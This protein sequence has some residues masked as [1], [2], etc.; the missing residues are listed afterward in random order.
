MQKIGSIVWY[1]NGEPTAVESAFRSA[2][3]REA[4]EGAGVHVGW[5]MRNGT[6][7]RYGTKYELFSGVEVYDKAA[8]LFAIRWS[9]KRA[10]HRMGV[11]LQFAMAEPDIDNMFAKLSAAESRCSELAT[12]VSNLKSVVRQAT[13]DLKKTRHLF[14]SKEIA[15]VR[16][17]LENAVSL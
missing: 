4:E 5:I 10:F 1:S 8:I 12:T 3:E 7:S 16:C 6:L 13:A 9:M 14:G 15:K 11:P 2:T 17:N